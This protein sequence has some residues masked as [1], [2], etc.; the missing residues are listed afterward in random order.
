MSFNLKTIL[1]SKITWAIATTVVGYF[2]YNKYKSRKRKIF[3]SFHSKRDAKYRNILKAWQ[4]NKDFEFDFYDTSVGV[5]IK[6]EDDATVK[7][8][9]SRKV[10]ESNLILCII[11]EET[12]KR[13][14]V[15]WE[16]EKA[17]E[18]N[19]KIIA[20]K[21]ENHYKAPKCL[22]NSNIKFEKFSEKNINAAIKNS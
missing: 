13:P 12:H 4:K 3:V 21:I 5:S 22:L 19:I 8:V 6:S 10:N 1:N 7:R 17:K 14:M 18:L 9:I 15:N 20:S 16:L 11:G 2:I